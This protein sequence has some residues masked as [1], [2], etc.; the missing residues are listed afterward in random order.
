[1]CTRCIGVERKKEIEYLKIKLN[2]EKKYNVDYNLSN[3]K[4]IDLGYITSGP[5]SGNHSRDLLLLLDFVYSKSNN[6]NDR[7][8]PD[9]VNEDYWYYTLE[10]SDAESGDECL[11]NY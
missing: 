2:S 8:E 4:Y 1:M 3:N 9:N 10:N 6:L 11:Y 5:S 7:K